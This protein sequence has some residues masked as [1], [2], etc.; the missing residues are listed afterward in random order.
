MEKEARLRHI[1]QIYHQSIQGFHGAPA[2]VLVLQ[3]G[4]KATVQGCLQP[5]QLRLALIRLL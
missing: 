4:Q 1:Q 5:L 3:G 2:L